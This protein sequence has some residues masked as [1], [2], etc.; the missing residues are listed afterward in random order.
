MGIIA[1]PI[2]ADPSALFSAAITSSWS[3]RDPVTGRFGG[4]SVVREEQVQRFS[5][6]GQLFEPR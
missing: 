5:A 3:T 4:Q 6:A 1:L 2:K